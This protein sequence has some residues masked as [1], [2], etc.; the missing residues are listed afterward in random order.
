MN[1]AWYIF[2]I[3]TAVLVVV[4]A[5]E[6]FRILFTSRVTP[7][8]TTEPQVTYTSGNQSNTT[9]VTP[10]QTTTSTTPTGDT[11]TLQSVFGNSI[12]VKDFKNDPAIVKDPVNPGYYYF[13]YHV[14]EGVPDP[15]ATTSPPYIIQYIDR[16]QYFN[17]SI[18]Q[19]PIGAVRNEMQQYLLAHLGITQNKLCQ[20]KY[21]VY[22]S[23]TIAPADLPANIGFS[24][25][26]GATQ[27]AH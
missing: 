21:D 9:T 20:L 17:I 26:P 2:L 7:S 16:T 19:S 10:T 5:F 22:V 6:G 8:Q 24:F 4:F 23:S 15:T 18:L 13:G 3:L 14:N 11:L 25:C 12:T 1:K 27:F